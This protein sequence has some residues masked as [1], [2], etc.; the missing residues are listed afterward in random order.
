MTKK[1]KIFYCLDCH[2]Q[3]L[4]ATDRC[5]G[6]SSKNIFSEETSETEEEASSV[7]EV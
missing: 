3:G 5:Y 4:T 2:A 7:E 1:S 6:C